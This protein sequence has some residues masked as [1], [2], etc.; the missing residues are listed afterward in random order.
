M[1]NWNFYLSKF[2]LA[3]LIFLILPLLPINHSLDRKPWIKV[4]WQYTDTTIPLKYYFFL[5]YQVWPMF[6]KRW[7]RFRNVV[8]EQF[9]RE[10]SKGL[11][12]P[13]LWYTMVLLNS[14]GK[15]CIPKEVSSLVLLFHYLTWTHFSSRKYFFSGLKYSINFW[16]LASKSLSFPVFF[17]GSKK[18]LW[19][20]TT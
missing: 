12:D 2:S 11:S 6:H 19:S 1:P 17:W 16:A 20:Q 9:I 14:T 10:H 7:L 5:S 13:N 18:C 8:L 3:P 4:V 15:K